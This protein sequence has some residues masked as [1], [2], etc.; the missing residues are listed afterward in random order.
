MTTLPDEELLPALATVED[1]CEREGLDP[2]SLSDIQRTKIERLL[3]D[4]SA[5]VRRY[6]KQ[7]F[8]I[9]ISTI[10]LN[11]RFRS[12]SDLPQ[13]PVIRIIAED[14]RSYHGDLD[15]WCPGSGVQEVTYEHGYT[16]VPD[17]IV[18]VV[19]GMVQRTM[20]VHQLARTGVA[21]QQVGPYSISFAGWATG[22][23]LTLSPEERRELKTWRTPMAGSLLGRW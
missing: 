19:C 23:N 13:K 4:A 12:V 21:S 10:K 11:P 5:K 1:V 16:R 8:T 20:N 6:T 2:S 15:D 7:D 3:V 17:D 9:G 22:G 18:A 14:G